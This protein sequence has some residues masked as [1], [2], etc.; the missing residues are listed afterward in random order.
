MYGFG[1]NCPSWMAAL[2][3][4]R[5]AAVQLSRS[6]NIKRTL[7]EIQEQAK[8]EARIYGREAEPIFQAAAEKGKQA[9]NAAMEKASGV[10]DGAAQGEE[11]SAFDD[12]DLSDIDLDDTDEKK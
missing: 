1:N 6:V 5:E 2:S 3:F 11:P 10:K 7:K 4:Y 9:F 8:Q 12:L